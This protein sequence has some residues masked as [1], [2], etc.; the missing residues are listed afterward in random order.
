MIMVTDIHIIRR[1]FQVGRS[2]ENG[3]FVRN[4]WEN[5]GFVR[6]SWENVGA[7]QFICDF[8]RFS[9][10][11]PKFTSM[12]TANLITSPGPNGSFRQSGLC[13]FMSSSWGMLLLYVQ[14]MGNVVTGPCKSLEYSVKHYRKAYRSVHCCSMSFNFGGRCEP[15][16]LTRKQNFND[17][18]R[19]TT[20]TSLWYKMSVHFGWGHEPGR[21]SHFSGL[22][23]G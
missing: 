9:D 23:A 22:P 16:S 12:T 8:I 13:Y 19:P 2:W 15:H 17:M 5:G 21:K 14:P 10:T 18:E 11:N 20:F 3:G 7:H 1:S 6:D 4:S